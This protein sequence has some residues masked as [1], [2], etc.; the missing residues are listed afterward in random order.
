M[1][2]IKS[3]ESL[4]IDELERGDYVLVA[5][6]FGD[7]EK[8]REFINNNVGQIIQMDNNGYESN[9]LVKYENVTNDIQTYFMTH[10]NANTPDIRS[11][12][13]YIN[14]R[15]IIAHSKNI[16]EIKS[17]ISANKYNL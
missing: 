5:Q 4:M 8:V 12:T 13:K 15:N 14:S 10:F 17:M 16:D 1:K 6:K 2:Y 9:I 11:Y 3:Y 7:T